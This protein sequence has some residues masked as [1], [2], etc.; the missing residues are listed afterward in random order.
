MKKL[1]P[2]VFLLGS[3]ALV[4]FLLSRGPATAP[5]GAKPAAPLSGPTLEGKT[6]SLAEHKGKVVLVDF[7]ATWCAPCK[8]EVPELVA[9]QKELGPKG[10]VVLGVSMDEDQSKVAPFAKS[11]SVNYPI[12]LLGTEMAPPGWTVPGLPTAYLIGRDGAV[13]KRYF[14]SKD[15]GELRVDVD[16]ALAL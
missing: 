15:A 14:G 2:A 6:A 5:G 7:W 16:A 1:A 11:K 9:L 4:Y 8:A 10:F 3:A 12:I 13:I